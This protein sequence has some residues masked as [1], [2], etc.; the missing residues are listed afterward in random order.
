[1]A[2]NVLIIHGH[3]DP[4]QS[5]STNKIVADL[6]KAFPTAEV[7]NLAEIYP[8]WKFDVTKEQQKVLDADIIVIQ[9][10]VF[11]Y[12]LPSITQKW[13]EDVFTHG[14]A[15]GSNVTTLHGKKLILSVTTGGP[16]EA[17]TALGKQVADCFDRFDVIAKFTGLEF[18][19]FVGSYGHL[20]L[21]HTPEDLNEKCDKVV[22]QIKEA[23]EK[24]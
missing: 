6:A 16:Q 18:Y 8:D 13:L 15:Y 22:A 17:Y 4:S 2:K 1:M 3:T 20:A 19:K 9:A 21:T 5:Y 12:S 7:D 10:P 11:W 23:I 24:A 14:F